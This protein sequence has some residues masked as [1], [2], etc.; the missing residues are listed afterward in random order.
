MDFSL[1]GKEIKY[2]RK[3][4]GLSQKELSEDICTQA[5][6]SKIEKGE[7]YP[8][9]PTLY[10]ISKRL[11]VDINYFFDISSSPNLPYVNEVSNLLLKSRRE[12]NF[13]EI[14]EIVNHEKKNPIFNK[15][16][17]NKQLLLWY[18]GICFYELKKDKNTALSLLQE[19]IDLT[20]TNE[21]VYN[22]R[23]IEILNSIA[24]IYYD[25][26]EFQKAIELLEENLVQLQ[27]IPYIV[28]PTIK[29]RIYYNLAKS[30][31]RLDKFQ[32]S[33]E[34]CNIGIDWCRQS[35][36]LYLFA[37][38]HYQMGYNYELLNQIEQAVFYIE[39]AYN[40]FLLLKDKKYIPYMDKQLE[41]LR[42]LMVVK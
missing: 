41:N 9:A 15:I 36:T 1:I 35:N 39:N 13:N 31:T 30:F 16:P 17:H 32:E 40:I 37:E 5:Q 20:R 8:L 10:L 21:K 26:E 6:I 12:R 3:S 33:L 42:G 11:G 38:L 14:W 23:E 27:R 29:T 34:I 25:N 7:V 28:D 22:E 4:L 18:E 24:V 19:A 2:L